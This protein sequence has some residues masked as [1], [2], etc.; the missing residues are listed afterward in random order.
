[1]LRWWGFLIAA[2]SF[3]TACSIGVFS[4]RRP[5]EIL[6]LVGN[7][8]LLRQ[9]GECTLAS[10]GVPVVVLVFAGREDRMSIL[11]KYIDVLM[12]KGLV[13]EVHLWDFE[14]TDSDRRYVHGLKDA[15]HLVLGSDG[16]QKRWIEPY[17]YYAQ[18]G[19]FTPLCAGWNKHDFV[20]V[21][22]DD[23][24]VFIDTSKFGNFVDYVAKH[25]ELFIVHANVVNNG[26]A[27]H[28]QYQHLPDTVRQEAPTEMMEYPPGGYCGELWKSGKAAVQLL[29]TFLKHPENF[30]WEYNG[31]NEQP[32]L[33]FQAPDVVRDG[34]GRFSINFF[35]IRIDAMDDAV[36]FLD[37]S[38]G[39]DELALTVSATKLGKLECMFT[40]MN[41]VHLGFY[42]QS[43]DILQMLPAFRALANSWPEWLR[44]WHV[45]LMRR[46]DDAAVVGAAGGAWARMAG[47]RGAVPRWRVPAAAPA[48]QA[49]DLSTSPLS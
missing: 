44:Q 2:L 40:P 1:M 16:V 8:T 20:L 21:K 25:P 29:K 27:A 24:I 34:Q 35:G 23:D 36:R 19:A 38:D 46:G 43:N 9:G 26:V 3:H 31:D 17:R 13:H 11:M 22:A 37:T 7:H 28:Y 33:Y 39:D 45:P 15:S 10:G 14:R 48:R 5:Y 41:V 18:D 32:C 42:P 30:H 4:R 12:Q 6:D 49:S 47:E